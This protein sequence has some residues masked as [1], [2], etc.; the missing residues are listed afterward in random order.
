MSKLGEGLALYL[1]YT[2][3][4]DAKLPPNL[5]ERAR[6]AVLKSKTKLDDLTLAISE[7]IQHLVKLLTQHGVTGRT[8]QIGRASCRERV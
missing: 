7:T 4:S 1:A 3:T 2:L 8:W 6:M 5:L